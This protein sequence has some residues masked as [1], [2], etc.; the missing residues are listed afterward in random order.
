MT[1][2]DSSN[3]SLINFFSPL[4]LPLPLALPCPSLPSNRRARTHTSSPLQSG[5]GV[6]LPNFARVCGELRPLS[7]TYSARPSDRPSQPSVLL[8]T[9]LLQSSHSTTYLPTYSN[10]TCRHRRRLSSPSSS[11]S[12]LLPSS[13]LHLLLLLEVDGLSVHLARSVLFLFPPSSAV[14]SLQ[15]NFELAHHRFPAA[16][17]RPALLSISPSSISFTHHHLLAHQSAADSS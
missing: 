2:S 7:T 11:F 6:A 8:G 1:S 3:Y 17:R 15:V 4:P 12:S 16:L 10:L 5:R 13:I 9:T 14:L